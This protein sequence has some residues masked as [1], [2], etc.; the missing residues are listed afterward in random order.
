[1][2]WRAIECQKK[3]DIPNVLEQLLRAREESNGSFNI[4]TDLSDQKVCNSVVA[5]VFESFGCLLHLWSPISC[6]L[7]M[8]AENSSGCCPTHQIF[9]VILIHR[10]SQQRQAQQQNGCA[11]IVHH[12]HRKHNGT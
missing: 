9:V 3:N 11:S 12:H 5:V 10:R 2:T 6:E 7:S 4:L 8:D 1:M